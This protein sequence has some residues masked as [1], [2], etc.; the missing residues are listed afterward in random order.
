M[1]LAASEKVY[2]HGKLKAELALL[3]CAESNGLSVFADE[4]HLVDASGYKTERFL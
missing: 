1:L 2:S 3:D 4:E